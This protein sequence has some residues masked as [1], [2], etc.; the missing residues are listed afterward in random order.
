VTGIHH[1]TQ[2][3]NKCVDNEEDSVKDIPLMY[4]NYIVIVII[5]SEQKIGGSMLVLL[6]I[7]WKQQQGMWHRHFTHI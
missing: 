3:W 6:F 4:V 5:V 7:L 2:K 1:L